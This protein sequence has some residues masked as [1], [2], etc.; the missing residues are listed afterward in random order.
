[1]FLF[2]FFHFR[3]GNI[4][5]E[6]KSL[7]CQLALIVPEFGIDA[8]MR[9]YDF[10]FGVTAVSFGVEADDVVGVHLVSYPCHSTQGPAIDS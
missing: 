5:L 6:H 7:G 2:L 3:I 4:R 8:Y 10:D 1:M 9:F